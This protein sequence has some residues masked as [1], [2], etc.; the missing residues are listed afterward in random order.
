MEKPDKRL[1]QFAGHAKRLVRGS[2]KMLQ[3]A[4]QME[5][6]VAE[7]PEKV[8]R[9]LSDEFS[10]SY[11]YELSQI[12]LC[13]LLLAA[14][15]Q[16]DKF[17]KTIKDSPDP[18]GAVLDLMEAE[19]ADDTPID[20]KGG[21]GG[22]FKEEDVLAILMATLKSMVSLG[23]YGQYMPELVGQIKAGSD[24]AL[25]RWLDPETG[26]VSPGKFIPILEES[27]MILEVGAWAIGKALLE[28]RD[29]RL[30]NG[31][32]LRIAVNVSTIQL[33]QRDF[34]NTVR[35]AIDGLGTAATQ[36]DLEITESMIMEDVENNVKKLAAI[37]DM[38]VNIAVDDF[39][40]GYSSLGYLAKLPINALKIDRSFIATMTSDCHSMTL[41]S[42][43]ISLASALDL[44][45]IA[46]GVESEEQAKILRLLKCDEMQGYFFSKPLPADK[47]EAFL[48]PNASLAP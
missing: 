2:E 25:I 29:W 8:E 45:V 47:V 6:E 39:G 31:D 14:L 32:S 11:L 26:L 41:V 9:Y 20:W 48:R 34:V 27:G 38:G 33:K 16:L 35:R 30:P 4:E 10:W 43:I 12:Q 15:G 5:R 24:E 40:T 46:E 28:A 3:A 18:K 19:M 37:R 22:K 42:T 1:E 13:T 21:Q 17:V 23:L 7:K 36:L 44:K